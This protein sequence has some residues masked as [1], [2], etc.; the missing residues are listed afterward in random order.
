MNGI[1]PSQEPA[2][3]FKAM[4]G[5]NMSR[6]EGLFALLSNGFSET[7]KVVIIAMCGVRPLWA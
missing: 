4:L 6:S 1:A 3:N 5:V 7:A 2:G